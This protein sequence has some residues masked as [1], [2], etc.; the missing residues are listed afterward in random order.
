[1]KLHPSSW[2][3][4]AVYSKFDMAQ[5]TDKNND[6][7]LDAAREKLS[8]MEGRPFDVDKVLAQNRAQE[9]RKR[10]VQKRVDAKLEDVIRSARERRHELRAQ[11]IAKENQLLKEKEEKFQN[12]KHLF[13]KKVREKK[14]SD[15]D[16]AGR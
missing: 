6:E 15:T 16:R 9:E 4:R 5:Q 2:R 12:D 3:M 10:E 13:G 7:G 11:G 8:E 14:V 1:M